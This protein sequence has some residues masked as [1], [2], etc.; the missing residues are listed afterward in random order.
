MAY[1]D[2]ILTPGQIVVIY[3]DPLTCKKPEGEAR[4][5]YSAT[6][7]ERD[8]PLEHWCVRFLGSNEKADRM[9]KV[10]ISKKEAK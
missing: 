6:Q 3:E 1:R 5:V 2:N 8:S 7:P 4:L 9:I 10:Q